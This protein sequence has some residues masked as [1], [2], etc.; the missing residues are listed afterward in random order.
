MAESQTYVAL[1]RHQD[2]F[3]IER[4]IALLYTREST[5]HQSVMFRIGR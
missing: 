1:L 5:Q 2:M 4:P 3:V